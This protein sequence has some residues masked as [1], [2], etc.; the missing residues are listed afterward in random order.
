MS[1]LQESK[2]QSFKQWLLIILEYKA[3]NLLRILEISSYFIIII[4]NLD[5]IQNIS[6][7]PTLLNY[8]PHIYRETWK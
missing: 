1:L 6:P 4:L 7:K 8:I 5:Y 3:L 2:I